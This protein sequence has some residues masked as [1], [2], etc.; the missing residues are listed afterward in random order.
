MLARLVVARDSLVAAAG[1]LR[2]DR[3]RE[4]DR[5]SPAAGARSRP[6]RVSVDPKSASRKPRSQQPRR[7]SSR[8]AAAK[9]PLP[10]TARRGSLAA[11]L[12]RLAANVRA[13]RPSRGSLAAALGRLAANVRAHRPSR[14]S[15]AAALGRL[16]ANVR[17][18]PA[19]VLW[20]PSGQ[21]QPDS[22]AV[23]AGLSFVWPGL[24]Q[25]FIGRRRAAAL[26]ALPA[27]LIVVLLG[28]QLSQGALMFATSMWNPSYFV[29]VTAAVVGLGVLRA[30][31]V[32]HAFLSAPRERPSRPLEIGFVAALLVVIVAT[33]GLF[34][35]GA[36]AWYDTSV[37]VQSND[38]V[39]GLEATAAPGE[40]TAEPIVLDTSFGLAG[41]EGPQTSARPSNP[42]RITFLI[43][44]TDYMEGRAHNLTD[45]LMIVSMDRSTGKV[46]MVSV[47][48]DTSA[49]ELYYGGWVPSSFRINTLL[50][51]AKSPS[52]GSPDP[53]M[54][55]LENEIGFLV[56]IPVD[57]YAALDL[58]GFGAMIDA[59]G[60][61]DVYN[62]HEI[63]DLSTGIVLGKGQVHL[64]GALAMKY[65]RS[66]EGANGSDYARS[67]RQQD[68]LVALK[69][70]VTSPAV[71]PN[72]ANLLSLAGKYIATDFPLSTARDY[73]SSVQHVTSIEK[74]VLAPPYSHHP[75]TSSTGG[76]WTSQ[77][78]I[79]HVARLSVELF[80]QDSL[81]Y[82]RYGVEPEGCV[83]NPY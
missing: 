55:T 70:K 10:P 32:C 54:K 33:H 12:G 5:P 20:A 29:A 69:Q 11:A 7:Q 74:C 80:G 47:P 17:A 60:G 63:Y 14:G 26:L 16:A 53:P 34:A 83:A 50:L 82:G 18:R 8:A 13:H 59:V 56:G 45:S 78:D 15:L 28:L 39:A 57:Y 40:P 25:L 2:R 37:S 65:V 42:N 23:A 44:G 6:R 30:V 72:L 4:P 21:P 75:P 1:G 62:P 41:T 46:A 24:G 31:A 76:Y 61:V 43:V 19:E 71:L 81:Y 49:F 58:G 51:Y 22:P 36:W 79:S 52:F 38:F 27:L 77:L 68:V 48:R 64:N 73:V 3:P 67:S 35:T 66:R 9:S